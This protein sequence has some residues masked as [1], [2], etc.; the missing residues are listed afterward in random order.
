MLN[1]SETVELL[2]VVLS[3]WVA[4]FALAITLFLILLITGTQRYISTSLA[5]SV[6]GRTALL[7]FMGN[8]FVLICT[9]VGIGFSFIY[10]FGGSL[11]LFTAEAFAVLFLILTKLVG[12]L[13]DSISTRGT[14]FTIVTAALSLGLLIPALNYLW[15]T[16]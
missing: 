11:G 16:N 1:N 12:L 7:I 3:G 8:V 10:Y 13:P 2:G 6:A 5:E 15:L 14:L 9:L 4:G